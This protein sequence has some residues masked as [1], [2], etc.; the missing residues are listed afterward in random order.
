MAMTISNRRNDIQLLM[1]LD[2][3]PVSHFRLREFENA[4]GLA[5]VHPRLLDAL[6]RT[7]R[8][9]CA[10]AG[11]DVW[12]II[13]DAIRTQ[14]DLE[15]LATRY[16]WIDEGGK[17]ARDSKHLSKYGGI[18]VDL[19][20]VNARTKERV[21]QSDFGA[22]CRNHFDWVKDDYA[23]GHVHADLRNSAKT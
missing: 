13:T 5:V 15:R 16:G 17:V 11:E 12:V 4:E 7:R 14:R 2:G 22:I 6:E 9:L 1:Y 8:D 19:V 18:A 3:E 10:K 21:P 20:A 23:D